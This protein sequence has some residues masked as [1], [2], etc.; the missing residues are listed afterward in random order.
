MQHII[1]PTTS[2]VQG[3]LWKVNNRS[4]TT[5][6]IIKYISLQWK[7]KTKT[8]YVGFGEIINGQQILYVVISTKNYIFM[9]KLLTRLKFIN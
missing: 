7:K 8:K 3:P 1:Y 4:G 5:S 9:V 2:S 6:T